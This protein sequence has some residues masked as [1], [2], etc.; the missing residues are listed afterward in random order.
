[1]GNDIPHGVPPGVIAGWV[2]TCL[3][4]LEQASARTALTL[5]PVSSLE[6]LGRLRYLALRTVLFPAS[7]MPLEEVLRRARDLNERLREAAGRRGATVVELE[8]AWYG[9]DPIHVRRRHRRGAWIRILSPWAVGEGRD[10]PAAGSRPLGALPRL[11][12]QVWSRFGRPRRRAQPC[13]RLAD[14]ATIALF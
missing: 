2:E 3:E 9:L 13:A 14:G 5:L 8:P 1:V 10:R 7:R 6:R 12:P 4:R 11:R